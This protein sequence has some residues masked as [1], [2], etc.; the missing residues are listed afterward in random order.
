MRSTVKNTKLMI[1]FIDC[2][3]LFTEK[4]KIEFEDGGFLKLKNELCFNSLNDITYYYHWRSK[5]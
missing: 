2:D 1:S 5:K 4:S 3:D